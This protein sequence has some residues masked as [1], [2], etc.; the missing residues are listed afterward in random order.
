MKIV[1]SKYSIKPENYHKRTPLI[2]KKIA[3]ILLAT[4]LVVDPLML[5]IP[6]FPN[7]E[8][9][10]WGWTAFVVLFKFVSKTI[11]EEADNGS[12]T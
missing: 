8:W 3:D 1:G 4:I 6:D 9:V 12:T 10:I 5:S 7:K 2:L 11:T